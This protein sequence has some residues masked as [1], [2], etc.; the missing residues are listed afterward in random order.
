MDHLYKLKHTKELAAWNAGYN[1]SGDWDPARRP[2][3]SA[4]KAKAKEAVKKKGRS[5]G[6]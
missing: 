2:E 6:S 3:A 1:G 4:A 5:G